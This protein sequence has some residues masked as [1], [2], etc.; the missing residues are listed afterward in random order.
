[1][2]RLG[3]EILDDAKQAGANAIV[4]ACPMCQNNLD[5]RQAAMARESS[6]DLPIIFVSQ[7]VGLALGLDDVTLGMQRHFVSTQSVLDLSSKALPAHKGGAGLMARIGVFVCHC[8]E[9]IG[10]TV[11]CARVAQALG[12]LPGVVHAMD[13]KYMCSDPGQALIKQAVAEKK[14]DGVVVAA[15]SPHMHEKTFRKAVA[16]AGLN[17]FLCEMAN[18]REHCSWIHEDRDAATA[19]AIDVGRT[20]IEKIKH[21]VPLEADSDSGAAARAGHRRRHRWH[22]GGAGHRRRWPRGHPGGEGAFDWRPHEPALGDL[23]HAG[24]F[25]VHP[26]AANGGGLPAPRASS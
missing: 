13:Y 16:G 2:L 24:L 26:H 25:A 1:M 3:R 10:R 14:L 22:S 8:G 17:R 5:M 21:N 7:L 12:E 20:I 11:D 15:C 9:N 23:P 6:F 18:I 4:V 19:K